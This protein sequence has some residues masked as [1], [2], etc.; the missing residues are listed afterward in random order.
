MKDYNE[1]SD[2][3]DSFEQREL[4]IGDEYFPTNSSVAQKVD[5]QNRFKEFFGDTIVFGLEERTKTKIFEI[6]HTL[7]KELP[8]CFCQ[9]IYSH[10]IHMTLHDLSSSPVLHDV[11]AEVSEN[12]RKLREI[13]KDRPIFP[14]TIRMQ[15]NN[16]SNSMHISL[17]MALKPT[18]EHEYE[19]LM[20][21]YELFDEV[22]DLKRPLV[23]HITLAYYNQYGFS[24]QLVSELKNLV[25]ELNKQSFE[26]V[27]NTEK[28]L[29]QTLQA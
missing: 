25:K 10:N 24:E 15:T 23:P 29:Y 26:V 16:V 7:Y 18:D 1:Y 17:V 11:E 28:L 8:E 5:E 21:L 6:M 14:Q 3:L 22:R 4:L 27:L 19:K 12:E 20:K 2:W 13:L 9:R